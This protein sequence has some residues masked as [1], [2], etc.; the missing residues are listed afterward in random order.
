MADRRFDRKRYIAF[1]LVSGADSV[2]RR[3]L[4][5]A[6]ENK[7]QRSGRKI[8]FEIILIRAGRGIILTSHLEAKNLRELLSS[9]SRDE[10]GFELR[11][12]GTSGTILTLKQRFFRGQ[13]LS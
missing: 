1:E 2:G 10:H 4:A 13:D 12:L 11:T 5:K 6:I 8:G 7:L 3:M 9:F